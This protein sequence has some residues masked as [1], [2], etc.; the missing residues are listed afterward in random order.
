MAFTAWKKSAFGI[1]L[2][3]I[4]P[5]LDWIRE[6]RGISPYSVRMRES[7]DQNNSKYGHSLCSVLQMLFVS[8]SKKNGLNVDPQNPN[9]KSVYIFYLMWFL[10]NHWRKWNHRD[11]IHYRQGIKVYKVHMH[12]FREKNPL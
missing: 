3:H 9:D 5:H 10:F 1:I 6:I 8:L 12:W 11:I 4:F 7:L 2:V